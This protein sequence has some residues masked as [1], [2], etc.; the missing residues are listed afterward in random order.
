M[1][2]TQQEPEGRCGEAPGVSTL[3]RGVA[4]ASLLQGPALGVEAAPHGEEMIKPN[5]L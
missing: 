3:W 4:R 2:N 1:S 5:G